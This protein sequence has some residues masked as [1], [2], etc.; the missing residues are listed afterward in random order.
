MEIER[1]D[2]SLTGMLKLVKSKYENDQIEYT[3]VFSSQLIPK[4]TSDFVTLLVK[5]Q[6]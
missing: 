1:D 4:Q 3:L 6:T 5:Y 2:I